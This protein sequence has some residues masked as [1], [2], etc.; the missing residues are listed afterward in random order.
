MAKSTKTRKKA[1]K[2]K[3]GGRA[4]STGRSGLY[5]RTAAQLKT[6]RQ[7]GSDRF[8]KPSK[9]EKA[10]VRLL[11]FEH[12]GEEHLGVEDVQHWG[13]NP[14]NERASVT[15]LVDDCPICDLEQQVEEK[16]WRR[17]RPQRVFL[18]NIILRKGGEDG[19]DV[20]KI[21]RLPPTAWAQFLEFFAD[22]ELRE[23]YGDILD[24]KKGRD[25]RIVRSG[26]G[27]DTRYNVTILPRTSPVALDVNP[28]DL[29]TV[30]RAA[31][32]YADV[33]KMADAF[34]S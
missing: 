20:H 1:T 32:D 7:G 27:F 19:Q 4:K 23:E 10:T 17:I 22:E 9:D 13:I 28:V 24:H 34:S 25:F 29:F 33:E 14:E 18:C 6:A 12:E 8:W 31:P 11:S 21:M 3:S 30:L 26:D 16:A 5:D 15:C 2:K